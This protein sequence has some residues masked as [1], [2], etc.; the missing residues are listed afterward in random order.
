[1]RP[2][3]DPR[4][5]FN[6]WHLAGSKYLSAYLGAR[7][8]LQ[9]NALDEVPRFARELDDYEPWA[10]PECNFSMLFRSG[11]EKFCLR[12]K[13]PNSR[14]TCV[15][16]CTPS[17]LQPFIHPYVLVDPPFRFRI[18]DDRHAEEQLLVL[19]RLAGYRD[20]R[21]PINGHPVDAIAGTGGICG[22]AKFWKTKPIGPHTV[23]VLDNYAKS[24]D[25]E[26]I[27]GPLLSVLASVGRFSRG[28][29]LSLK[30][31][32]DALSLMRKENIIGIRMDQGGRTA[33]VTEAALEFFWSPVFEHVN[34]IASAT[35]SALPRLSQ[36]VVSES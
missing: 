36:T 18:V 3:L 2:R 31:K 20:A 34:E 15:S 12:L 11:V 16:G 10:C 5:L 28:H 6:L 17:D 4:S 21:R 35:P 22:E 29:P 1:M 23:R 19:L 13:G 14:E 26:E 8:S 27:T 7:G 30:R 9:A 33:P 25:E 24:P 32:S